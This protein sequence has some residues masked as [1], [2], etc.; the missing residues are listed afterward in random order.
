MRV[1]RA[2]VLG[3]CFGVRDSLAVIEGIEDPRAVTIHGELVHN[4]IVQLKLAARGFAAR[5]ESERKRSLPETPTVLI[6]AH[7]VSDR[8]RKRLES[9]GKQ[10]VDTT[11]PLVT[12]VH[13]ASGALQAEGYHVLVIGKRGH[14]EVEGITEDLHDFD[15]IES[16]EEVRSYPH[17]RL[18]IVCQTTATEANVA[19]IRAA[20]AALNSGALVKF[21][22]TV[23]LPTKEHQRALERL[24]E[25]VD[26]VV[27]V[28]GRNSNN[29]RQLAD[30]CRE[31][32]KPVIH[33][34]RAADLDP[35]WFQHFAAVGLTAGTSTLA[36]TVD[37]VHRALVWIG[38]DSGN[39]D[40][41]DEQHSVDRAGFRAVE[42]G[43]SA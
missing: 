39:R 3:M 11:C 15:V 5:D 31:H 28:G 4:E 36:E 10:L 42:G 16:A 29:T 25:K 18:G 26:A 24:L 43:P 19:S 8:E 21:I 23:C 32:G 13:R 7:G 20:V 14:V 17:A 1:I 2:D 33:I 30:R 40:T 41:A 37:E 35:A 38:A 12:R 9:A 22:D 34:Q 6:T 27:V